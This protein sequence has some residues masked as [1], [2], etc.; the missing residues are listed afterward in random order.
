MSADGRHRALEVAVG[1]PGPE[2][3]HVAV[4][5]QAA[6]VQDAE[7]TEDMEGRCPRGPANKHAVLRTRRRAAAL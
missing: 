4:A 6:G 5:Q 7:D 1:Q 3:L 2:P